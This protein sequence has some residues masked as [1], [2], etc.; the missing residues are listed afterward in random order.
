MSA[1]KRVRRGSLVM[2]AAAGPVLI[3]EANLQVAARAGLIAGQ[4]AGLK[5]EAAALSVKETT[6]L[7][8]APGSRLTIRRPSRA[9]VSRPVTVDP[10]SGR[11]AMPSRQ[12][13][14]PTTLPDG[15]P[16]PNS[17]STV[18][19]SARASASATR[20]DGSV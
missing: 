14:K 8:P 3:A 10:R 11:S 17:C 15:S 4:V 19:P 1:R 18:R 12:A 5:A 7:C 16:G 13:L 9:I 20:S 6:R 2:P